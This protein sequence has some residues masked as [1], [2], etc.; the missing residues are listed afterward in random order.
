M[1]PEKPNHADPSG[2]SLSEN[3]PS[4]PAEGS[5]GRKAA[6]SPRGV[7]ATL[8]PG[9]PYRR[10]RPPSEPIWLLAE[11]MGVEVLHLPPN[12]TLKEERW[13]VAAALAKVAKPDLESDQAEA[14]RVGPY[15]QRKNRTRAAGKQERWAFKVLLSMY[16][17]EQVA[18][19]PGSRLAGKAVWEKRRSDVPW[20]PRFCE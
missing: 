6:T 1:R 5:L 3:R 8:T 18:W 9:R 7:K 13:A 2:K 11:R 17:P 12:L 20:N 16:E 14:E 10:H 19:P 4:P 15:R